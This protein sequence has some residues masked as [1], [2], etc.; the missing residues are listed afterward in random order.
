MIYYVMRLKIVILL[1]H[2][3][4]LIIIIIILCTRIMQIH[5]RL[6]Y[7]YRYSFNLIFLWHQLQ[8]S[9]H[10]FPRSRILLLALAI[11][12]VINY[13]HKLQMQLDPECQNYRK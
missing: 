5:C 4:V 9:I 13:K 6:H 7:K 2:I 8:E 1:A 10:N 3:V 12:S 11:N